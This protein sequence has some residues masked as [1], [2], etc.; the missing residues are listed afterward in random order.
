MKVCLTN[1]GKYNEGELVY[2]WLTL[3]ADEAEI[4]EAMEAI[5]INEEYEE[6]FLTD[7]ECPIS[8]LIGEYSS[9]ET[10]NEIAEK[11]AETDNIELVKA[12]MN[13]FGMGVDEAIDKAD[14]VLYYQV[15]S[16]KNED[17]AYAI[18][19]QCGGIE[20]SGANLESYFDYEAFGRDLSFDLDMILEDWDAEE[21]ERIE[22]LSDQ[23]LGEW[24]VFEALGS[25][26]CLGKETLE[27]YFDYEAYGRDLYFDFTFDDEAMIAIS[28]Y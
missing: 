13:S 24:Y 12:L 6:Y 16:E 21:K 20:E 2:T 5:G 1:L 14:D 4:A 10:L 18:I 26:E 27:R 9:L 8:G 22:S 15:D 25:L 23:E 7:W 11:I 17:L 3:P 19:E 28:N